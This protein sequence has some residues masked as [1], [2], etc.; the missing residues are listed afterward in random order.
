MPKDTFAVKC[1][2]TLSA[3]PADSASS[4][5]DSSSSCPCPA[6]VTRRA[7]AA[8]LRR[9]PDPEPGSSMGVSRTRRQR[10]RP[11]HGGE[12]PT[13]FRQVLGFG[14]ESTR[15]GVVKIDSAQGVVE[16]AGDAMSDQCRH[17]HFR[18]K[19]EGARTIETRVGVDARIWHKNSRDA[20][21]VPHTSMY[22]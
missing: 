7:A 2:G 8:V 17:V 11:I 13:C 14:H 3:A 21:P 9:R 19:P 4:W 15:D 18:F 6:L 5:P 16:V 22:R 10:V 20:V 1:P 12:K